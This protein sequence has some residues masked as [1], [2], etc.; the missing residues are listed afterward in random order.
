MDF[1]QSAKQ[2]AGVK[3]AGNLLAKSS[4]AIRSQTTAAVAAE[5][6]HGGMTESERR[7]AIGILEI[8]ARDVERQVR[9]SLSEQVK[10]CPF[11]GAFAGRATGRGYRYGVPARH[12]ALV[13]VERQ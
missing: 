6:A 7:I 9:E 12:S 2:E 10:N 4:T 11:L 1:R 13:R 3:K 5:F 8:M